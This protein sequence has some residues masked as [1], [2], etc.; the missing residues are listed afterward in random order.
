MRFS[1]RKWQ[2]KIMVL[3]KAQSKTGF[4]IASLA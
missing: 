2:K 3:V 4:S 1:G